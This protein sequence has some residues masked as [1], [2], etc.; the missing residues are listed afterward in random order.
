[1]VDYDSMRLIGTKMDFSVFFFISV[2]V[3]LRTQRIKYK[4]RIAGYQQWEQGIIEV[5][6][7]DITPT[8]LTSANGD[9]RL[10]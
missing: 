8:A 9:S 7:P 5:E 1:M 10:D 6:L 2:F 4:R 3:S